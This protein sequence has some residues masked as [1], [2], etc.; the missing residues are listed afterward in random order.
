MQLTLSVPDKYRIMVITVV[1]KVGKY[2]I[3]GIASRPIGRAVILVIIYVENVIVF[4]G[5]VIMC[6]TSL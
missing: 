5:K 2:I 4:I 1:L 6:L 3:I